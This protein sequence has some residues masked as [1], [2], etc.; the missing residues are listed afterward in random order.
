MTVDLS[1]AIR[2]FLALGLVLL[3]LVL[4]WAVVG[5]PL[6]DAR[7]EAENTIERLAPL[8]E[9]NRTVERD[10]PALQAELQQAKNRG[11]S[12]T[13]FLTGPSDAIAAAQLQSR[14]KAAVEHTNGNLRSIQ[15]LPVREE[16]PY[17]RLSVRADSVMDLAALEHVLYEVEASTAPY[18]FVDNI[19]VRQEEHGRAN[20]PSDDRSLGVRIDVSGY[21]RAGS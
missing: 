14:V 8:L 5:A 17:R 15:V 6:I 7:T 21:V 2:R 16:G 10:I 12:D 4:L 3:A 11:N 1:P 13:G 20:K 9:R 18:L 19:E